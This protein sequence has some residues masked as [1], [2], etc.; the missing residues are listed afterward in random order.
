MAT[1]PPFFPCC[2]S[3][4]CPPN[5]FID[6][7]IS[8][9][10]EPISALQG[11]MISQSDD[12]SQ[13]HPLLLLALGNIPSFQSVSVTAR[14]LSKSSAVLSCRLYNCSFCSGLHLSHF[15]SSMISRFSVL[16]LPICLRSLSFSLFNSFSKS[17]SSPFLRSLERSISA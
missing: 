11:R 9:S 8:L 3:P 7:S 15:A 1:S 12:A 4:L 5:C 10:S 6:M 2:F 16:M 14:K 17:L 13:V